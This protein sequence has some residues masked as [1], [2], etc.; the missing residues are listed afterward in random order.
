MSLLQV[1]SK[2]QTLASLVPKIGVWHHLL[3]LIQIGPECFAPFNSFPSSLRQLVPAKQKPETSL[4]SHTLGEL[5]DVLSHHLP[6]RTPLSVPPPLLMLGNGHFPAFNVT[7]HLA[8]GFKQFQ[9]GSA[10][11]I[12]QWAGNLSVGR[13]PRFQSQGLFSHFQLRGDP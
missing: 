1:Q 8:S 9:V 3:V 10:K 4:S 13:L 5:W 7:R 12:V 11:E 2:E 6:A